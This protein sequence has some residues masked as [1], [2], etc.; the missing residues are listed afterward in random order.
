MEIPLD[1]MVKVNEVIVLSLPWRAPHPGDRQGHRTEASNQNYSASARALSSPGS[2]EFS[3]VSLVFVSSA[4]RLSAGLHSSWLH[5]CCMRCLTLLPTT[6]LP[7]PWEI[8]WETGGS[9]SHPD[10]IL[11][12]ITWTVWFSDWFLISPSFICFNE[13][14]SDGKKTKQKRGVIDAGIHFSLLDFLP[15]LSSNSAN[16]LK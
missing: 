4:H 2:C 5:W 12:H 15:V 7:W 16:T 14:F 9:R 6:P 1:F 3:R 8:C 11:V 10:W 13:F